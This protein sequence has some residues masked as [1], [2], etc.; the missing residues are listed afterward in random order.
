MVNHLIL[1]VRQDRI[2]LL[3][4]G[5]N[6]RYPIIIGACLNSSIVPNVD[7]KCHGIRSC[8]I[9]YLPGFK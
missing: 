9:D 4:F 8:I 6:I 1:M 2:A 3:T 5:F 7:K